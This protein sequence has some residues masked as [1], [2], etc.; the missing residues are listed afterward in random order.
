MYLY[1][2]LNYFTE[3]TIVNKQNSDT[4]RTD[5]SKTVPNKIEKE[6]S[7]KETRKG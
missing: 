6:N 4:S 7:V 3:S 1:S 2:A 5:P